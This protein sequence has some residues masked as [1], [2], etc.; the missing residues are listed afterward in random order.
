M[1]LVVHRPFM[2]ASKITGIMDLG[3]NLIKQLKKKLRN[4]VSILII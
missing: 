3:L 4:R 2:G 1:E